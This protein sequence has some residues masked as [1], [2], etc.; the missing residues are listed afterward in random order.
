M[1]MTVHI[2]ASQIWNYLSDLG[3]E[4][5]MV[6][7][8][9]IAVTFSSNVAVYHHIDSHVYSFVYLHNDAEYIVRTPIHD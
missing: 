2:H 4:D 9:I 8:E 1:I 7:W 6:Q 3:I 5:I